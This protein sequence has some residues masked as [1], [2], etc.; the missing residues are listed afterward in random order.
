VLT[1][2][3]CAR[4]QKRRIHHQH[5]SQHLMQHQQEPSSSS[6][7]LSHQSFQNNKWLCRYFL[8]PTALAKRAAAKISQI[9]SYFLIDANFSIYL[10]TIEQQRMEFFK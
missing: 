6:S 9:H 2:E 8:L 5:H 10:L 4:Q 1:G 7:W 3:E